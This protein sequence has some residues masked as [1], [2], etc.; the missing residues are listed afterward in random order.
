MIVVIRGESRCYNKVIYRI[1]PDLC[2]DMSGLLFFAALIIVHCHRAARYPV[3]PVT[4][5]DIYTLIWSDLN[6]RLRRQLLIY[7]IGSICIS[8]KIKDQLKWVRT[9]YVGANNLK[10]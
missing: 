1:R 2:H 8:I 7:S 3:L 4:P 10:K 9:Q 5:H 6:S